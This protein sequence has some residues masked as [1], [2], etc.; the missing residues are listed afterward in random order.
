[1]D[2]NMWW[3]MAD[4]DKRYVIWL[5]MVENPSGKMNVT[6]RIQFYFYILD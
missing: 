6:L 2:E 5:Y 1:M 4:N 3:K